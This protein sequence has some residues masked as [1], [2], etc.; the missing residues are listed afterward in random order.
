MLDKYIHGGHTVYDIKVHMVWVTKYRYPILRK[1]VGYRLRDL[2]RQE[3]EARQIGLLAGHIR[4]DHVHLLLSIPP[5]L[6]ISQVAKYLKGCSSHFLQDEFQELKKRYWG[7]HIWTR[8][9]FCVSVGEMTEE[10]ITMY[11]E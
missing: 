8:E 7:Q 11:I 1:D 5:T 2:L 4:S 9:Y 6:S 10:M 3:C